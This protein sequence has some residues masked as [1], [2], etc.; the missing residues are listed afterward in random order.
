M[1]FA[2]EGPETVRRPPLSSGLHG[3]VSWR[4][5]DEKPKNSHITREDEHLPYGA[6]AACR[7]RGRQH[8]GE[9]AGGDLRCFALSIGNISS[10]KWSSYLGLRPRPRV[11]WRS[12][13]QDKHRQVRRRAWN[14]LNAA[15]CLL[16]LPLLFDAAGRQCDRTSPMS[17]VNSR[18]HSLQSRH[19]T[20]PYILQQKQISDTKANKQ[21]HFRELFYSS[22]CE[23]I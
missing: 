4:T 15:S 7:C 2:H 10:S 5:A 1:R 8:G 19:S 12:Q 6:C 9:E 16:S 14:N 22:R 23:T 11:H 13:M 3:R 18:A 21:R 20:N 17:P